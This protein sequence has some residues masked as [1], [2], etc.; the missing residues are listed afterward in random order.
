[1]Q[2]KICV[3]LD[4][5]AASAAMGRA[6]DFSNV[7]R[8][9]LAIHYENDKAVSQQTLY[10]T[11]VGTRGDRVSAASGKG[12]A[13]IISE[14]YVNISSNYQGGDDIYMFGWSRGAA[15]AR[16]IIGLI[17]HVGLLGPDYLQYLDRVWTIYRIEQQRRRTPNS[18]SP[19]MVRLERQAREDIDGKLWVGGDAPRIRLVGLFDTVPG[20]SW[21]HFKVFGNLNY[22]DRPLES[23]VDVGI[24]LLSVDDRRSPSFDPLLWKG[25]SRENQ[26]LEQIWMPGVHGD[27]G[28]NSGCGVLS[29]LALVTMIDRVQEHCPDL[30]FA[31]WNIG[32]IKD[33]IS[34]HTDVCIS[35]ECSGLKAFLRRSPRKIGVVDLDSETVHPMVHDLLDREIQLRGHSTRYR[36]VHIEPS[37][38]AAPLGNLARSV[39]NDFYNK[40]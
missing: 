37:L 24:H 26:I 32:R 27:V 21:D 10:F 25:R 4:G 1:M 2:K 6:Q 13:Q 20:N 19:A 5:S 9:N 22:D 14:A 11:G 39:L 18:V 8:L 33:Q 38:S 36:R 40:L 17:D 12:L 16:T 31:D 15:A 3:F 29:D 34:R 7:F 23:V 35:N 28:G 30:R